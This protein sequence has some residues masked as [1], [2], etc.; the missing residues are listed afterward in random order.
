MD[1]RSSKLSTKIFRQS[2]SDSSGSETANPNSVPSKTDLAISKN[3][4]NDSLTDSSLIVVAS[5]TTNSNANLGSSSSSSGISNQ[6]SSTN[7]TVN[8][9][10][11]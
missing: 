10:L 11:G 1:F 4:Q 2:S 3:Q 7:N 5:G 6:S 9:S 8:S